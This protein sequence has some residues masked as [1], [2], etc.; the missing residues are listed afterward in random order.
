MAIRPRSIG[1]TIAERLRG[2]LGRLLKKRGFWITAGALLVILIFTKSCFTYVPPNMVGVRQVYYGS[3]AGM[4][5]GGYT[6]GTYFMVPGYERLHLLPSD[7]QIVNFTDSKAEGSRSSRTAA[8]IKV[9]TSDGYNVLLDVTVIYRIVDP[10]VVLTEA[11]VGRAFEDRLVVPRADRIL[12]KTLG[13]LNSEEMYRGPKR[14]EK[15]RHAEEQLAA[16]LAPLGIEVDAV[17]VRN[18]VYDDRYQQVIEAR[19]IKNQT[20]FLRQAEAR[21]AIE[22]RK[23]DTIIA[24]GAAQQQTE[25]SRGDAEV[26]KLKAE[27]ELYRRQRSAEGNLKVELAA[28]QGTQLENAALQG[29]G[30]E[31]MVGL[32]MAETLT[33]V[34]VLVLSSD[35][36]QG[37]NPLDLSSILRKFEVK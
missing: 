9:Q 19:N 15:S 2:F 10:Y 20:V 25:L 22:E 4:Q 33:G 34:Q 3:G 37:F 32:K 35:G 13:E 8:G 12:R 16:E 31:N 30:S 11:G 5:K 14:I 26:Q 17:L 1:D 36:P 24:Q 7:M 6:A 28:A 18:Y 21:A 27:A 29:P 23:R